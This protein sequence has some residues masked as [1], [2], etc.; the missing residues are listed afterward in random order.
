MFLLPPYHQCQSIEGNGTQSTNIS[1]W[2]GLILSLSTTGLLVQGSLQPLQQLS[3]L[4]TTIPL[5]RQRQQ[6]PTLTQPVKIVCMANTS[7]HAESGGMAC[8]RPPVHP[9]KP[10]PWRD[11]AILACLPPPVPP[12]PVRSRS[13]PVVRLRP[14]PV[15]GPRPSDRPRKPHHWPDSQSDY[16]I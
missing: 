12:T 11:I 13:A 6:L 15:P 14:P 3:N 1:Q 7:R 9:R 4:N 16:Y 10:C 5:H 2:C 8:T